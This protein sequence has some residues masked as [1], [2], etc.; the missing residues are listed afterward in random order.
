MYALLWSAGSCKRVWNVSG[1]IK[2][3]QRNRESGSVIDNP[4]YTYTPGTNR[5]ASVSDAVDATQEPW[6]AETGL[7][8]LRRQRQSQDRAGAVCDRRGHLRPPQ[9]AHLPDE[10]RCDHDVSLPRGGAA[11]H[12]TGYHR[13]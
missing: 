5:L 7:I 8:H 3:L 9:L 13:D 12:E 4:T 11:D 10:Q 1:N 2:A 6:D